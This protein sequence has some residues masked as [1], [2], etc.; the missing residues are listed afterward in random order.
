MAHKPLTWYSTAIEA[1]RGVSLDGKTALVT[2]GET[3]TADITEFALLS[4][5]SVH[6][7]AFAFTS[8][9]RVT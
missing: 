6:T 7:D 8:R 3:D 5:A 9:R 4:A 2:G 1:L